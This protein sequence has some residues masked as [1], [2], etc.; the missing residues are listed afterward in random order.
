MLFSSGIA[1]LDPATG[2]APADD[3]QQVANTFTN[4]KQAVADAGGTLAD[5][6]QVT[7]ALQ[8]EAVGRLVSP[9]WQA[10]FPDAHTGPT[11]RTIIRRH[12]PYAIEVQF[13]ANV[14][15]RP[16]EAREQ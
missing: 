11:R 9:L 1:G 14:T 15:K 8:S 16:D 12:L 7:V 2:L 6:G 5:I 13:V 10:T 4:L 3:Y